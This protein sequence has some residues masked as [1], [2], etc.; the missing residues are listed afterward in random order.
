MCHNSPVFIHEY[1]RKLEMMQGPILPLSFGA[2]RRSKI[3][4]VA[5]KLIEKLHANDECELDFEGPHSLQQIFTSL[6]FIDKDSSSDRSS[7]GTE[8]HRSYFIEH[9]SRDQYTLVRELQNFIYSE[10]LNGEFRGLDENEILRKLSLNGEF[11]KAVNELINDRISACIWSCVRLVFSNVTRDSTFK[12]DMLAHMLL[13]H[14]F[15]GEEGFSILF[16]DDV[17][18]NT[19][20]GRLVK[21]LRFSEAYQHLLNLI[22]NESAMSWDRSGYKHKIVYDARIQSYSY[23]LMEIVLRDVNLLPPIL[24]QLYQRY[25]GLISELL[26]LISKENYIVGVL[27]EK[28]RSSSPGLPGIINI[29][30]DPELASEIIEVISQHQ[31]PDIWSDSYLVNHFIEGST[32]LMQIGKELKRQVRI[33]NMLGSYA[34]IHNRAEREN[35]TGTLRG[36]RTETGTDEVPTENRIEFGGMPTVPVPRVTREN[37]PNMEHGENDNEQEY[38]GEDESW[39]VGNWRESFAIWIQKNIENEN[40]NEIWDVVELEHESDIYNIVAR[41]PPSE[42]SRELIFK[43]IVEVIALDVC[44]MYYNPVLSGSQ[45][46]NCFNRR[47]ISEI[48]EHVKVKVRNLI[49]QGTMRPSWEGWL[50]WWNIGGKLQIFASIRRIVRNESSHVFRM[51]IDYVELHFINLNAQLRTKLAPLLQRRNDPEMRTYID[52]LYDGIIASAIGKGS[53]EDL[54]YSDI[55]ELEF[56]MYN[57]RNIKLFRLQLRGSLLKLSEELANIASFPPQ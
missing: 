37:N 24:N 43:G 10:D 40:Y 25:I 29:E 19:E 22:S 16:E 4:L 38:E 8:I 44:L 12:Y 45:F 20:F 33:L 53:M 6:R 26:A 23:G 30:Y 57:R 46:F 18:N 50:Q 52:K 31:Q 42:G 34:V 13:Q 5:E 56:M 47:V 3:P 54:S 32:S 7:C 49:Y 28:L 41:G 55:T 36:L 35:R 9:E 15:T 11:N 27:T 14:R 1:Q 48:Y 17:L 39:D 21:E 2:E 51:L